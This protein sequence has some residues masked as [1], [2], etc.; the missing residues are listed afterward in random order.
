VSD[1]ISKDMGVGIVGAR[2]DNGRWLIEEEHVLM[3]LQYRRDR[4]KFQRGSTT[5]EQGGEPDRRSYDA[6]TAGAGCPVE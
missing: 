6:W 1:P 3:V 5:H 4:G 2:N